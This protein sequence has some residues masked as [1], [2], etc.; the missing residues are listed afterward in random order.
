VTAVRDDN[1]AG[2]YRTLNKMRKQAISQG[3]EF[4]PHALFPTEPGEAYPEVAFIQVSRHGKLRQE[5]AR[6]MFRADELDS[7]EKLTEYY[8]GGSFELWARADFNGKP[9]GITRK[10]TWPMEGAPKPLNE[11]EAVQQEAEDAPPRMPAQAGGMPTDTTSL[12]FMMMQQQQQQAAAQADRQ[13]Q[14]LVTILTNANTQ[15]IEASKA[16]AAL[17]AGVMSQKG[18]EAASLVSATGQL[19][20]TFATNAKPQAAA[21][22][23]EE[24]L[25]IIETLKKLKAADLTGGKE[26]SIT[27][28]VGALAAVVP[29]FAQMQAM[30]LERDKFEAEQR[31]L[32]EGGAPSQTPPNGH[33]TDGSP[34]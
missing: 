11:L 31:R 17:I 9:G 19:A 33:V 25:K 14:L 5:F 24:I 12:L 10:Q 18:N 32:Y 30:Q 27:E 7:L 4:P 20:Q 23:S 34:S 16:N 2:S 13:M 6:R 26:D 8:G 15:A 28:I 29:G 22:G 3:K 1:V 21:T